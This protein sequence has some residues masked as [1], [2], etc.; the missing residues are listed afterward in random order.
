MSPAK[1]VVSLVSLA[2][3]LSVLGCNE[4]VDSLDQ[5]LED[6]DEELVDVD[7]IAELPLDPDL[8][9]ANAAPRYVGPIVELPLDQPELAHACTMQFNP[10]C[11]ADGETYA[12]A[13]IASVYGA[14]VA[15]PGL[16]LP[17]EGSPL[18]PPPNEAVRRRSGGIVDPRGPQ[19]RDTWR[20]R[21]FQ[22]DPGT[23]RQ[24]ERARFEREQLIV[25]G[26]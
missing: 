14:A 16:C 11:G 8:R 19:G 24:L 10:V 15:H 7:P 3:S 1:L 18:P 22:L 6:E 5:A 25:S 2:L 13:C 12:N 23:E 26:T 17:F 20:E 4:E 9:I 21:P